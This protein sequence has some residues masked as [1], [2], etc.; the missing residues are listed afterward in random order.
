MVQ[1]TT[2]DGGYTIPEDITHRG[3]IYTWLTARSK[4]ELNAIDCGDKEYPDSRGAKASDHNLTKI[5]I[6]QGIVE[7]YKRLTSEAIYA[8]FARNWDV[9]EN[10]LAEKDVLAETIREL[11]YIPAFHVRN[12]E[13]Q[14]RIVDL[15]RYAPIT[16]PAELAIENLFIEGLLPWDE[17]GLCIA[18]HKDDKEKIGRE[19]NSLYKTTEETIDACISNDVTNWGSCTAT[20][21]KVAALVTSAL[22]LYPEEKVEAKWISVE[23]IPT[24]FVDKSLSALKMG[25][26]LSHSFVYLKTPDSQTGLDLSGVPFNWLP[27][28]RYYSMDVWRGS[29]IEYYENL[30]AVRLLDQKTNEPINWKD[31]VAL[32]PLL[33]KVVGVYLLMN[34][35]FEDA[36][37]NLE[38]AVKVKPYDYNAHALLASARN[39]T[40]TFLRQ[41]AALIRNEFGVN[42][43]EASLAEFQASLKKDILKLG[44]DYAIG[45]IEEE[46]KE[47]HKR[48]VLPSVI[49]SY[50]VQWSDFEKRAGRRDDALSVI[51]KGLE[52]LPGN[53]ILLWELAH[54]ILGR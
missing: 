31:I 25:E 1:P 13:Y 10:I 46:I 53:P 5:E 21:R 14:R 12:R 17:G 6:F 26:T 9:W 11:G 35:E 22:V 45:M 37:T 18:Y 48:N 49:A 54:Y 30:L 4:D 52:N 50:Y 3:R 44:L 38:D 20:A 15:L 7:E 8:G 32:S 47:F 28:I 36:E 40:I 23:G 2:I 41:K 24:V 43:F 27:P 16:G 42:S 19:D 33:H 34:G 51:K 29:L 39:I